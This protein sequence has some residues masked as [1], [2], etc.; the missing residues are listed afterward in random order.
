[1]GL[2]L[3]TWKFSRLIKRHDKAGVLLRIA[4]NNCQALIDNSL[5]GIYIVQDGPITFCNARYARMHGY[6]PDEMMGM[7]SPD[8]VHPIDGS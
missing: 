5:T 2:G 3:A 4:Q 8:L 7:A 6:R 1:M